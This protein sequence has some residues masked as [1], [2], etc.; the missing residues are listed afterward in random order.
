MIANATYIV[1]PLPREIFGDKLICRVYGRCFSE[2]QV[3]FWDYGYLLDSLLPK[4]GYSSM[5][6]LPSQDGYRLSF[7]LEL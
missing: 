4:D 3:L 6:I 5:I 2:L 1:F 7:S